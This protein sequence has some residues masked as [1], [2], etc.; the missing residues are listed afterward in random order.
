MYI[1]IYCPKETFLGLGKNDGLLIE[2]ILKVELK[3]ATF[4]DLMEGSRHKVE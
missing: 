2:A 1:Y 3:S 4:Y